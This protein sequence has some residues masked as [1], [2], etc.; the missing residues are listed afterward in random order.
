MAASPPLH[1]CEANASFSFPQVQHHPPPFPN[2]FFV[3]QS[4]ER[5]LFCL[6]RQKRFFLAFWGKMQAKSQKIR[7]N[8]IRG[9]H[10]G[11]PGARFSFPAPKTARKRRCTFC[12]SLLCK[13]VGNRLRGG[14]LNTNF[15][16]A[17]YIY[18][19]LYARR[20]LSRGKE[21]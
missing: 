14:D 18:L 5:N 15:A 20:G 2:I 9:G 21:R 19:I 11:C 8:G 17:I 10:H 4:H 13:E 16:Y 6:P 12:V 1:V 3:V 7:Q